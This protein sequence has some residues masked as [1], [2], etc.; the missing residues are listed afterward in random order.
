[1]Y[2]RYEYDGYKF[3]SRED[4]NSY[5]VDSQDNAYCFATNYGGYK[6]DDCSDRVS[7]EEDREYYDRHYRS[8]EK[9]KKFYHGEFEEFEIKHETEKAYLLKDEE[10]YFWCPKSLIIEPIIVKNCIKCR[11]WKG[12]NREA[13]FN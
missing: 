9:D 7:Y 11:I 1:M 4:M 8:F 2:Q 13:I 12:L 10:K 5:I 3:D 6:E